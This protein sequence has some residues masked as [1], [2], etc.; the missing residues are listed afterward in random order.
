MEVVTR[1]NRKSLGAHTK[2]DTTI[3]SGWD[4]RKSQ[5]SCTVPASVPQVNKKKKE[6]KMGGEEEAPDGEERHPSLARLL[7]RSKRAQNIG[8]GGCVVCL[9]EHATT[10]S[11]EGPRQV[12]KGCGEIGTGLVLPRHFGRVEKASAC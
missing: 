8:D 2:L 9:R 7:E 10:S 6:R 4:V 1:I 3:V 11:G 5:E 12:K